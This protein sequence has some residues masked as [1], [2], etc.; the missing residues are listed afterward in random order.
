MTRLLNSLSHRYT[1]VAS[2]TYSLPIIGNLLWQ[3]LQT[4]K[5]IIA[6]VVGTIVELLVFLLLS[7]VLSIFYLLASTIATTT[8][9]TVNYFMSRGWVFETGRHSARKELLIFFV[10]SIG[11]V[12][13][14]QLFLLFF[15]EMAA[16]QDLPAKL[17]AIALTA[18]V[19]FFA[20]K[21]I[22]FKG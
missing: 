5:F 21:M 16:M 20:K 13:L 12:A 22:V 19:N 17:L 3:N 6:G 10:I 4:I 18:F 8:A 9:I 1:K 15:V 7:D 2:W 14:N 11:S